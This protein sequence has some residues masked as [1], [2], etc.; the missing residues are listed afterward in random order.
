MNH[1]PF[2]ISSNI[3]KEYFCDRKS[4]TQALTRLIVNGN[5]V[6]LI[7]PRRMGKSGLIHHFYLQSE[8][9]KNFSTVYID[10][11]QTSSFKEFVYLFGKAIYEN[12]VPKTLKWTKKFFQIL[13]SLSG[14]LSFDPVS[15]YPSFS[16]MLGEM[17]NPLLTLDE[18]FKFIESFDKDIIISIDEFQQIVKYPEK[19]V[20][21]ILRSYI[22]KQNRG[23]FIFSGSE[24]HIMQEMFLSHNRP[25]YQ[26]A[27]ILILE[28]I[29][30]K[31]YVDFAYKL[32]IDNNRKA[33][34]ESI[35]NLYSLFSGITFYM[36]KVLNI[37]FASQS[38]E[39]ICD[40]KLITESILNIIEANSIYYREILSNL[41]VRQKELLYALAVSKEADHIT[42][43]E[44]IKRYSL[45][46]ASS[47]Q[48]A[49]KQLLEKELITK[50]SNKYTLND[51]FF[52]LWI[53]QLY[54]PLPIKLFN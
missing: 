32:F 27:S 5:N 25:F 35:E 52:S 19:N 21:A 23:H 7:S 8:I 33:D 49:S 50:H 22:Q 10:I 54:G 2:Y 45:S 53:Q 44:F 3:P 46:S 28:S 13:Q 42:S 6:V 47:V 29:P 18:I 16:F 12:I 39:E 9:K 17:D 24:L 51:K 43:V 1:N 34:Y 48:S 14:K 40:E 11:L 20:E 26:S 15:G 4:E 31:V 41:P 38:E 30:K 36:Q 37:V